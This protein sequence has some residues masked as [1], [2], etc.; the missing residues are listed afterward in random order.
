MTNRA[1]LDA[2]TEWLQN[3]ISWLDKERRNGG[4]YV[5]L[6]TRLEECQ[7]ILQKHPALSQPGVAEWQT[8]ETAPKDET[9]FVCRNKNKPHVTYEAAIFRESESWEIPEEY[10]VLQNMTNDEPIDGDWEGLEWSPLPA[11]PVNTR[12]GGG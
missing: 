9:L 4:D 3:R 5:H 2:A 10:L 6:T 11:P 1:A 8:M 7:Y 12:T